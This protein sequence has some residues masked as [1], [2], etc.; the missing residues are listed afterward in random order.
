[1]MKDYPSAP[2]YHVVQREAT[3]T[4]PPLPETWQFQTH[5]SA[6]LPFEVPALLRRHILVQVELD[7]ETAT[8]TAEEEC[9]EAASADEGAA[10]QAEEETGKAADSQPDRPQSSA[11][12]GDNHV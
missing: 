9:K 6:P 1:M 2:K 8:T 10:E 3:W 12:G 4:G 7:D 11:N 5:S